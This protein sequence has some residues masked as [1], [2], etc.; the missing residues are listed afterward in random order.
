MC[1][2]GVSVESYNITSET[3]FKELFVDVVPVGIEFA[4]GT[5]GVQ[6]TPVNGANIS[7]KNVSGETMRG[8]DLLCIEADLRGHLLRVGIL[9]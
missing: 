3:Y 2:K 6:P 4:N 7:K 1:V 8:R 5:I 9:P